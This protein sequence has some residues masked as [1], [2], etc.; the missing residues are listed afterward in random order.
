MNKKSLAI[1]LLLIL[2]TII[3]FNINPVSAQQL[4]IDSVVPYPS[5]TDTI[6][7]ITITHIGPNASPGVFNPLNF[8]DSIDIDM[9]GDLQTFGDVQSV[10]VA[11]A[12]YGVTTFS[13]QYNMGEVTGTPTVYVRANNLQ[14][15]GEWFPYVIPEFPLIHLLPILM[16]VSIAV[17][18]IKSKITTKVPK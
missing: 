15:N 18:L 1:G 6:L 11:D 17:L 13:I 12:S 8:V 16:V 14:M 3:C 2:S 7:N 5:G 4:N 9:D 10:N